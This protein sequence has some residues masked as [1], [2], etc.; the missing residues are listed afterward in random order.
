MSPPG[1]ARTEDRGAENDGGRQDED[2]NRPPSNDPISRLKMA[3]VLTTQLLELVTSV[4]G[5]G[6]ITA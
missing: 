6:L 3:T 4:N 1:G 2:S 5:R